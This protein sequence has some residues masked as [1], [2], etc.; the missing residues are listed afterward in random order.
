M[1]SLLVVLA[2]AACASAAI[3]PAPIVV[4]APSHD[5]AI[6]QSHRLGG[7]FAYSTHEAHAY[8]VQTPIIGTRTVPVGVSY[9]PGTPIV[10]TS[11]HLVSHKVPQVIP[12]GAAPFHYP[13]AFG[14]VVA[15]APAAEA[16]VDTTAAEKPAVVS[17]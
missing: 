4:R 5:S 8:G 13:Y 12:Y 7:N 11:T 14:P 1:N 17:V 3:I 2:L 15:A 9:V 16:P 10:K 6:I